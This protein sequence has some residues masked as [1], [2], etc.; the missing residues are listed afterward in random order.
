MRPQAGWTVAWSA[1]L[2]LAAAIGCSKILGIEEGHLDDQGGTGAS[3]A[4]SGTGG[5]HPSSTASTGSGLGG[6]AECVEDGDCP[7]AGNPA[8]QTV[9]CVAGA[10]DVTTKGAGEP[11]TSQVAGDCKVTQCDGSGAVVEV[12]G[13]D[14]YDDGKAC[15]TDTCANG[16]P[17]NA[18]KAAGTGCKDDGG[19][20]CD[21]Q[22]ACVECLDNGDCSGQVCDEHAC[23]PATCVDGVKNGN[24][25]ALDCGGSCNPCADGLACAVS[26]DCISK[27]CQ[28]GVCKAPNCT[29]GLQNGAETDVDCGG[30]CQPCTTGKS[31][32]LAADCQSQVCFGGICQPP[33]C[34]D[35]KKNG[36]ETDVDC[37]GGQCSGCPDGKAC[38]GPTDCAGSVCSGGICCTAQS[39]A[40]TCANKCGPVINNCGQTVACGGCPTGETCQQNVCVCV[41]EPA[42]TTCAGKC[43]MVPNNCGQVVDC[44]PCDASTSGAGGADAGTCANGVQDGTE[45]GVDCGGGCPGCAACGGCAIGSDCAAGLT[46]SA[47]VCGPC[48]STDA[49]SD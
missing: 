34:T 40:L 32:A 14:P 27:V 9:A 37:G 6:G 12:P 43:G 36:S 49:G 22:G 24:E 42:S 11:T 33:K 48:G 39:Q 4:T 5:A 15:T 17:A 2:G 1:S 29:D 13:D 31:C 46:C 18:P 45:T 19:K 23:V 20:L 30:F 10:C 47:G 25:T 21:G 44:G 3:V 8:C 26:A 28:A 7:D 38:V 35:G 41:P 16:V